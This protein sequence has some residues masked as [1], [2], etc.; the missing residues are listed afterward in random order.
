MLHNSTRYSVT[1]KVQRIWKWACLRLK[2]WQDICARKGRNQK[3]IIL[4]DSDGL[5]SPQRRLMKASG[6]DTVSES[7]D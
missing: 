7:V 1:L 6:E 4:M 5:D 3:L 2:I